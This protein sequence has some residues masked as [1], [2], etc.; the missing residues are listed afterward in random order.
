MKE[1]VSLLL[2]RLFHFSE[3]AGAAPLIPLSSEA[4]SCGSLN[5]NIDF[6]PAGSGIEE[7]NMSAK[8]LAASPKIKIG[9]GECSS[10]V[11]SDSGHIQTAGHCVQSCME[12]QKLFHRD[13]K[14]SDAADPY[15][16][17]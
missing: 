7:L 5:Q 6:I 13:Q 8:V 16:I 4:I 9:T 17:D 15:S 2:L 3:T 10:S 1:M 12:Q 14:S 11:I